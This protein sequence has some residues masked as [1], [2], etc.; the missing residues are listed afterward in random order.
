MDTIAELTLELMGAQDSVTHLNEAGPAHQDETLEMIARRDAIRSQLHKYA[1]GLLDA[2][3]E[4][5]EIERR[6][7]LT[8]PDVTA[9]D[10]G[11][12]T[13]WRNARAAVDKARG[14]S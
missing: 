8:D 14:E 2:L 6:D 12:A 10:A 7:N 4:L 13:A 11:R 1:R 5:V 9:T 3:N